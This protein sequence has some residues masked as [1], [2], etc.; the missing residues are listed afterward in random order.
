MN[1][2]MTEASAR[3]FASYKGGF[4]MRNIFSTRAGII[5]VGAIIGVGAALLQYL[6]L[7]HI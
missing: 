7:I 1:W 4:V 2:I 6:S 3:N 5:I